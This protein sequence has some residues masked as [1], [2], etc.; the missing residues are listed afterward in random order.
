M[1]CL[2]NFLISLQNN[3]PF[4]NGGDLMADL[5]EALVKHRSNHI[6]GS[7]MAETRKKRI[8]SHIQN[9]LTQLEGCYKKHFYYTLT[10]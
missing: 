5:E 1:V 2:P 8:E 10:L 7:E 3:S 4:P 9:R 6:T